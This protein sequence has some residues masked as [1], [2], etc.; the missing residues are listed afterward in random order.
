[1]TNTQECYLSGYDNAFSA[2]AGVN[3]A[4]K[5]TISCNLHTKLNNYFLA[6]IKPITAFLKLN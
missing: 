2:L 1:M 6:Y 4:E 5:V 3:N